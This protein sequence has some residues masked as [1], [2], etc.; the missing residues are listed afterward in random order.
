MTSRKILTLAALVAAPLLCETLPNDLKL[1]VESK[2]KLLLEWSGDPKIVAAVK[3]H[4]ASLSAP[5]F[6][7]TSAMPLRATS[8]MTWAHGSRFPLKS[9]RTWP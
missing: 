7:H 4:N 3:A 1:K 2:A 8:S 6:S 9:L 5:G